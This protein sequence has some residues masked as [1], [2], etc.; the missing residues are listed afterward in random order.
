[1]LRTNASDGGQGYFCGW[2]KLH[3]LDPDGPREI[4]DVQTSYSDSGAMRPEGE[5]ATEIEGDMRNVVPGRS[6]DMVYSGSERFTERYV[7]RGG[8]YVL[9]E[10]VSSRVPTC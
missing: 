8:R 10:G 3:A 6:F 4:A 5:A 7:L 1:M 9:S 2:M